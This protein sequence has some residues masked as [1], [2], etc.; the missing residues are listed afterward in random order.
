MARKEFTYDATHPAYV[1]LQAEADALGISLQQRIH[2][3]IV[4]RYNVRHDLPY[5]A[6]LW[7]PGVPVQPTAPPEVADT[8]GAQALAEHWL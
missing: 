4:G 5:D 1:E 3:L 8:A 7:L 2:L 6:A